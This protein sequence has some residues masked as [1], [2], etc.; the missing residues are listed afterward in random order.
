MRKV[1]VLEK[2]SLEPN[3]CQ[4]TTVDSRPSTRTN[5]GTS[6]RP[7]EL[8]GPGQT[9]PLDLSGPRQEAVG[10]KTIDELERMKRGDGEREREAAGAS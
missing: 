2:G 3:S 9:S 10:S 1:A 8:Q 7:T 6:R 4:L 5:G